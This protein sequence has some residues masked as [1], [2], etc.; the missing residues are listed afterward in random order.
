MQES[1][2]KRGPN[3]GK[4][5]KMPIDV[6]T[7]SEAKLSRGLDHYESQVVV[8]SIRPTVLAYH[9]LTIAEPTYRYALAC[10]NFEGHLQV[11]AQ[12]QGGA[13][14]E[15]PLA[16]SFDDGHISNYVSAR[17]LLEKYSC[18]AIFFVIVGRIGQSP[19]YMTWDQLREM[20]AL[21][22]T[23]GAHGWSHKFLTSC[24]DSEL[25]M[26]LVR[27][28]EELETGLGMKVE[29]L[30]APHG[31]WDRRV[32]LACAKAGYRRLY[33]STPWQNPGRVGGLEIVGRLMVIRSMD[34]ARLINWLTMSRTQAGVH[35]MLH[36]CKQSLRFALGN[37]LYHRLWT[38]F[39][40]WNGADDAEELRRL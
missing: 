14:A 37:R 35:R 18:K 8:K 3:L 10:K 32:A 20:A 34:S 27:S 19:D 21:G 5:C 22:H 24:P 29:A 30:S 25:R 36:G 7:Q 40:G 11:A 26:E 23:I 39:A 16:L 28:K 6:V 31:R 17:P 15:P 4:E 2:P 38:R 9:E 12:L 33:T 1:E 13:C